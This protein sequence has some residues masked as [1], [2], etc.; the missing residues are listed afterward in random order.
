MLG[1]LV[2]ALALTIAAAAE[3]GATAL[4]GEIQSCAG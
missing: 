1:K 3:P 4:R 2:F